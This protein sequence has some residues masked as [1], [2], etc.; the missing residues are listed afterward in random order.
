MQLYITGTSPNDMQA[1]TALASHFVDI[2]LLYFADSLRL[3]VPVQCHA[4]DAQLLTQ[5]DII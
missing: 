2:V 1:V 4:F 3:F 5:N